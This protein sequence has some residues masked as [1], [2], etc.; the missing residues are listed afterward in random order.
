MDDNAIIAEMENNIRIT[1]DPMTNRLNTV[2]LDL[3][4]RVIVLE[5]KTTSVVA[6]EGNTETLL[7]NFVS[8]IRSIIPS[9]N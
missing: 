4:Q 1:V 6:S 2:L 5:T 9:A 8:K 3:L 7:T